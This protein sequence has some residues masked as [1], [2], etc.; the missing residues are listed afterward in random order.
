M[1]TVARSMFVCLRAEMK[2][3]E[4]IAEV[5]DGMTVETAAQFADEEILVLCRASRAEDRGRC[6]DVLRRHGLAP[7]PSR[8]RKF[9]PLA[10]KLALQLN[11]KKPST[12][13]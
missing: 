12:L 5:I 13:L 2:K 1:V 8:V 4:W 9:I 3:A 11:A 10:K 7:M 6:N